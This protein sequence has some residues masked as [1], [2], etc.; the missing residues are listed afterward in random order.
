M[1]DAEEFR[2]F[3]GGLSWS[4]SDRKLKD[5][6]EK[7]G[8]LLEARC[9]SSQIIVAKPCRIPL[10]SR[11][12]EVNEKAVAPTTVAS[13]AIITSKETTRQYEELFSNP[14]GLQ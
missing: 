1:V 8:K 6:F 9:L 13:F 2:C 10:A 7:F 5:S 3:V 12:L 14:V 4:T 11:P